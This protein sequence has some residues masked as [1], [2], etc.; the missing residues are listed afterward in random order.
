M[1]VL[2][3][4][5]ERFARLPGYEFPPRY[6]ETRSQSGVRVHYLDE[7]AGPVTFLCLHGQPT[8]SYL[9]RRMIPSIVG[10]GHRAVAPDLV[11]FGRSDK[12]DDDAFYTFFMHRRMLVEFIEQLDLRR[13]VLVCQDWGGLLGLTLPPEMPERFDGL[14]AMN[15]M[16]ASGDMPLG[17]GFLDWRAWN[18]AHPD[19]QVGK[20][21]QRACPQLTS[22]EC[23][24][25]EAPFPDVRYKAGVRRFPNLV[26]DNP[27]AEGAQLSRDARDWWRTQWQGRS[28]M[29]VGTKDPVLGSAAMRTLRSHIRGCP[30]PLELPDGG[31]FVQEWAEQFMPQALNALST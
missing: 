23:A 14:L 12:P 2:R 9:Y 19:M 27:D 18:N 11:G 5:E 10:A 31:H 8:W 28:F 30:P 13:I 21:M 16:F 20:L 25:Y 15:T 4:P 22:A 29:V 7:G 3:T 24:A 26:P 1:N 6:L 17:K